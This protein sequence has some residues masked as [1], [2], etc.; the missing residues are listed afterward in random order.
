VRSARS[1]IGSDTNDPDF[2]IRR[3]AQLLISYADSPIVG[4]G[5]GTRAPDAR[6][7]AR[8][9]VSDPLRLFTLLSRRE[10]TLLLYAGPGAASDTVER[11]E[12]TAHEAT[13]SAGEQLEA[14]VIAAPDA[15]VAS[16]VLPL[17]RD[18]D[19]DFARTYPADGEAAFLIAYAGSAGGLIPTLRLTFR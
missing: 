6:G 9:S 3:E 14:Y 19:G 16:T 1:G 18:T 11:F 7:L 8:D 2:A 13:A 10:H 12:R 15:D 4:P 5:G 17:I